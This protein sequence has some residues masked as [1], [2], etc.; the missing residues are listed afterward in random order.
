MSN[1]QAIYRVEGDEGPA[2][3][4][5]IDADL[6]GWSSSMHVK[7]LSTLKRYS[8]AGVIVVTS[9]T[10]PLSDVTYEFTTGDLTEGTW[11]LEFEF[12]HPTLNDYTLPNE[13]PVTMIVRK[14]LG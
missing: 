6:T 12:T 2:V 5:D 7:N 10:L 14:D 4:I 1:F 8:R 3:T 9:T 11:A 13:R